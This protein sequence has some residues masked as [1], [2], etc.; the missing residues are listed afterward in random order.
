MP[1]T[2]INK[3]VLGVHENGSFVFSRD[4]HQGHIQDDDVFFNWTTQDTMTVSRSGLPFRFGHEI[5]LD[6][7]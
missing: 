6:T 3:A 4:M 2:L 5:H 1:Q 7:F